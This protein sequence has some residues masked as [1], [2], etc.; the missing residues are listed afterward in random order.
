MGTQDGPK[1]HLVYKL[2][3]IISKMFYAECFLIMCPLLDKSDL[4]ACRSLA[5]K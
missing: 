1:H 4:S 2:E 5:I 3:P